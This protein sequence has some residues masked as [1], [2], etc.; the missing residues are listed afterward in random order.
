MQQ[1][2]EQSLNN[3]KIAGSGDYLRQKRE[4][5]G[6]E[7][8]TKTLYQEYLR[9]CLN[10]AGDAIRAYNSAEKAAADQQKQLAIKYFEIGESYK[11]CALQDYERVIKTLVKHDEEQTIHYIEVTLLYTAHRAGKALDNILNQ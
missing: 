11:E 9:G 10:Q 5:K 4:W 7:T 2:E 1:Q 8:M 3:N 6:S